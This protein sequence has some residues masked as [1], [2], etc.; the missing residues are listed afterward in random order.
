MC[1]PAQSL[2]ARI[3]RATASQI[4]IE[5]T[6]LV[7]KGSRYQSPGMRTGPGDAAEALGHIGAD[8]LSKQE[9]ASKFL[10]TLLVTSPSTWTEK[11]AALVRA[12]EVT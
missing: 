2:S 4:K 1:W 8:F 7:E 6:E 3:K 5:V 10:S 9:P 11:F 12:G